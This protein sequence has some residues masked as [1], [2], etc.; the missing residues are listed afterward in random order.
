M[1]T[2]TANA[3]TPD[4]PRVR[5]RMAPNHDFLLIAR[6]LKYRHEN[7]E[8]PLIICVHEFEVT[9]KTL[10]DIEYFTAVF[11]SNTFADTGRDF[12]EV[13]EDNPAA[14]KIWMQLLHGNLD[15][16]SYA[17]DITTVWHVLIVAHKYGF[18]ALGKEAKGWF[19]KW[20]KT[21]KSNF[22]ITDCREL[23]YPCYHFDEAE[24]FAAITKRL[25]YNNV[26]HIT[27]RRPEGVPAIQK[28]HRLDSTRVI[29][30]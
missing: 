5:Y 18:D 27:E 7:D 15:S 26:G 1:A 8:E 17:V 25:A 4:P 16:S 22:S 14:L 24:G 10:E 21:N 20:Y 6:E 28:Q 30:E 3:A 2:T 11:K 29:G 9:R 13:K 19:K 12:Y 23:L